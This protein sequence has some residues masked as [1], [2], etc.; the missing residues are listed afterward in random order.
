MVRVAA[1]RGSLSVMLVLC[2][3]GGGYIY[4]YMGYIGG[5]IGFRVVVFKICVGLMI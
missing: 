1:I 2:F 3:R 4:I 5:C